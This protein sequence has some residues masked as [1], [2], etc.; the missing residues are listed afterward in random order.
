M[1]FKKIHRSLGIA[2]GKRRYDLPLNKDGG[3]LFLKI[4]IAL[5]SFLAILALSGSFALSEMKDRWSSGL[6]NKAS[7]EIP[8]KDQAGNILTPDQIRSYS[9]QIYNALGQHPA[10]EN[11]T[12]MSEEEISSLVAPWLGDDMA[13]DQ[14]PLPGI[15]TVSFKDK[16]PLDKK[17]FASRLKD[18][19][20]MAR[21]DTHESWLNDVLRFTGALKFSAILIT[22]IIG[23]I[24]VVAIAGAVQSRMAVY[25]EELELLHLMG[26][27]DSY[28]S[29]QLQRFIF[30]LCLQGAVIGTVAGGL[31]LII[32]GWFAGE[33]DISLL[34]DFSL[35]AFQIIT[36]LALPLL[37]ALLATITARH[38]VLRTLSQMP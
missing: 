32:I 29:K 26:A 4:L 28:I 20:P 15:L 12:I 36:L 6:E 17:I 34:P 21:L 33:M 18:I 13:F 3:G 22:M 9:Q 23:L 19:A 8:A 14:I 27:A 38:T 16:V 37:I 2:K 7:I 10:V 31:A 1:K 24:T 11:V 25:R 30:I 5:M 35:N